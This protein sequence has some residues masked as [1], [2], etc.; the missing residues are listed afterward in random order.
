MATETRVGLPLTEWQRIYE[1][2]GAFELIDGEIVPVHPPKWTHSKQANRLAFAINR[3]ALPNELGEAFVETAFV[4]PDTDLSD[5]VK[6]SR[7]PDVLFITAER[8][9]AYEAQGEIVDDAPL[10]LVPD[11]VVEI[12]SPNDKYTDVQTKVAR[13]LRDGVNIVWLI[14][15]QTQTVTVHTA[16]SDTAT[17]RRAD[18]PLDGGAII[19]GFAVGVGTL[20]E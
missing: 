16:G 11:L 20:F 19:P 10:M 5:W 17:I 12:I 7:V 4:L 9:T 6:G 18:D 8:L 13:Y 14:D 3:V 1:E 2:D 15:P